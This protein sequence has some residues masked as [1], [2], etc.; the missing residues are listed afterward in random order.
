MASREVHHGDGVAWLSQASLGPEHAVVTSL[1]DV[2]EL[3]ALGFEGWRRWFIEVAALICRRL[4]P[5]SVA[6]FYQ[7]D[8]KRDGCWIDKAHLIQRGADEAGAQCLFH[9]VACRTTP[10]TTTF[11]RPA[12]GH[13]LALSRQF[14]LAPASSTPDVLPDLGQMTWSRATPM[15]VALGSCLFLRKHLGCRVVVDPFCGHGTNLA[16]ANSVGLD[17]IGV[18]LSKK[19]ARKARALVVELPV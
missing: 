12:Y 1:P 3:P 15:T 5:D 6:I 11:G 14:R 9:K 17:A 10:G 13:W 16:V 18:E 8:I 19:R 7:T 4:H 2:S